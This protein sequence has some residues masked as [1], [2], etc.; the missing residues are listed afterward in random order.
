MKATQYERRGRLAEI[1]HKETYIGSTLPSPSVPNPLPSVQPII[2]RSL[3][4][5]FESSFA[6]AA[7]GGGGDGAGGGPSACRFELPLLPPFPEDSG[8]GTSG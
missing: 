4:P 1:K 6:G 3:L 8:T 5:M 7:A 2:F